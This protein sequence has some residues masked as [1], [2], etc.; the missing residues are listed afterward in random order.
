M[1]TAYQRQQFA[2]ALRNLR[3]LVQ[4]FP[5]AVDALSRHLDRIEDDDPH[6]EARGLVAAARL[7]ATALELVI[8]DSEPGLRVQ[9]TISGKASPRPPLGARHFEYPSE[10]TGMVRLSA[11]RPS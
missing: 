9:W 5:S 6:H 1:V 10:V 4:Q 8:Q 3:T 7:L 11:M 2:G